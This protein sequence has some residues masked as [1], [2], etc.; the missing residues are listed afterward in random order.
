MSTAEPRVALEPLASGQRM[1]RVEFHDRY[2]AM[3]PGTTFELID[4]VVHMASPVGSNHGKRSFQVTVWL[5]NYVWETP[6]VEGLDNASVALDDDNEV[7][8]DL[9]LRVES[10]RGGRSR[11]LGNIIGGPPELVVEVA[12]SSRA[13]DLGAKRLAYERAGCLEYVVFTSKPADVHWHARLDDRLIRVEPDHD[14]I[15]RS[16]AF[17]GLWLDPAAF[18]AKDVPAIL[19]VLRRGLASPEH[20]AF[21]ARLAAAANDPTGEIP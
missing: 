8:P 16:V 5:G 20:A 2:E 4:G 6:R 21:A 12:D 7:Q 15:Y 1:G 10:N 13:I 17:P 11:E 3:P 14:G 9:F 19:E 18:L